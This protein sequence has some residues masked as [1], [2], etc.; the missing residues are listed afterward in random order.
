MLCFNYFFLPPVRTFTIADS[1]NII[2]W[3][4][5]MLTAIVAGELSAYADRR[6]LEAERQRL[7][8]AKL[9]GDLEEAFERASEPEALRRSEQ[10]KYDYGHDRFARFDLSACRDGFGAGDFSASGERLFD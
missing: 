2:A 9:Y 5:F 10:L 6:A 8:I 4:A 1:Q 3:A 7:E